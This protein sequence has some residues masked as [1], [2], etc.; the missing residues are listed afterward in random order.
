MA[1]VGLVPRLLVG[2]VSAQE[3]RT[4]SDNDDCGRAPSTAILAIVILVTL[5]VLPFTK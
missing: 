4:G 3:G 1:L 2:L 5:P